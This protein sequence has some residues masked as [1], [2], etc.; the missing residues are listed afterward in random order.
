MTTPFD[1]SE[2]QPYS[3]NGTSTISGQAFQKTNGGDVKFGAGNE[4]SLIP[5]T[6][7]TTEM[8]QAWRNRSWPGD[9]P[10]TNPQ[11]QKYVRQVV[12]DG[13]GNFEFQNVPAGNYYVV[14][15]I[16]WRVPNEIVPTGAVALTQTHVNAGQTVKVVVTSQ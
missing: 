10:Q 12:A 1:E 3:K 2:L 15:P 7:Y 16:F 14:C 4:V 9:P 5:V 13:N 11:L 8:A 6:S